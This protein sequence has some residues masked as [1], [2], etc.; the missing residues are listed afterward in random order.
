MCSS[1]LYVHALRDNDIRHIEKSHGNLSSNK[2]K[3]TDEDFLHINDIVK[4]YD[5]LY[6]GYKTKS[7]NNAVV[8]EKTMRN[9]TFY[10][11][12]VLSDGVL[13]TKQMLKVGNKSIPSFLKK[14][15]K[16]NG[17]PETDV[18]VQDRATGQSPL[19]NHVQN[20]GNTADI[21]I[22]R[23]GE[24]INRYGGGT[25]GA[26]EYNPDSL[27]ALADRY[28]AIKEGEEPRARIGVVPKSI[29]NSGQKVSQF[30][31]T[32][33]EAGATPESFVSEIEKGILE[34][35]FS[36]TVITD[37]NASD[38]ANGF[39]ERQGF[40]NSLNY[41][42]T[43]ISEN[44][45]IGKKDMSLG[46]KLYNEAANAGDYKTAKKI[47]GDI[48]AQ[49]T[50]SG[51]AVQA[52]RLLKKMD[53]DGN[54][55]SL[56]ITVQKLNNIGKGVKTRT[57]KPV[58]IKEELAEKLLKSKNT[59]E[60]N[61]NVEIIKDDIAKQ[62]KTSLMEKWNEWRYT[63]MLANP[64]THI[65]NIVGNAATKAMYSIKDDIGAVLES[66]GDYLSKSHGNG[67]LEYK[68][69][70]FFNPASKSDR[71]L[72]EYAKNDYDKYMKGVISGK[73]KFNDKSDILSRRDTFGTTK[74]GKLLNKIS[75]LNSKALDAE[76]NFFIRQNYSMSLAKYMKANKYTPEYLNS[77]NGQQAFDRAR[78]Y[79]AKEAL[80]S[81]FH[82]D[83]KVADKINE[84]QRLNI[85]TDIIVGGVL[86]FK[87]TPINIMKRSYEYSPFSL[88]KGTVKAVRA[89]DNDT[90]VNAMNDLAKGLT[91][92]GLLMFGAWLASEGILSSLLSDDRKMQALEKA[93]GKQG[94]ALNV[95]DKSIS[96]D[97]AAPTAVPILMGAAL[98]N[99]M[100]GTD[101]SSKFDLFGAIASIAE[102]VTQMTMLSSL[103][104]MID[105]VRFGESAPLDILQS[106]GKS[107]IGSGM[108]TVFGKVANTIDDT[109]RS[110]Y[111][112]K[113]SNMSASAQK[114]LQGIQYKT[115]F[116]NQS[117]PPTLDVW[118][119]RKSTRLN[120]SH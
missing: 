58:E 46:L 91:G 78:D 37:K 65:R 87:K 12:E 24:N 5:N 51:Q 102:P 82:D 79:A 72:L 80:E 86:P 56:E 6:L 100:R 107:Y 15:K 30:A 112:D 85:G 47:I 17:I 45:A 71:Q 1:D 61:R 103:Q 36:H 83:S 116:I 52:L 38:Y 10:V 16:I 117:L 114:I 64:T 3:V 11:E 13:G 74:V 59:E 32:A 9:R 39:I 23:S 77:F 108:P 54:L 42:N 19:G 98:Y 14:Y 60:M 21:I 94:L 109:Q 50:Q 92:T 106:V 33:I 118:G 115:P 7:G 67:G 53:P 93:E 4:D 70:S 81:T 96:L 104:N 105:D 22:S 69:K 95:A 40:A 2:Y 18:T 31:R 62:L 57:G 75:D 88:L 29:D 34:G 97:F 120:S 49:G 26:A 119:D 99:S 25:V 35:K 41:W 8:Y 73:N 101:N 66:A 89:N 76:D 111:I 20:A 55:Y 63:A 43:L 68:T 48:A 27:G 113:N 44:K 90:M 110:T 84:F 28:G